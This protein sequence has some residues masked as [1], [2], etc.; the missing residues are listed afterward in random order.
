MHRS[1]S[2]MTA[3][4]EDAAHLEERI[5]VELDQIAAN[6]R[7]LRDA[8]T[9]IAT[10]A[11]ILKWSLRSGGKIMFCGNGGSAADAKHLAAELMGR[12]LKDRAPLLALALPETHL[13]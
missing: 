6:M 11:E 3:E 2:F 1:D 7:L 10:A 8:A 13:R 5:C 12:Y 9:T 4:T